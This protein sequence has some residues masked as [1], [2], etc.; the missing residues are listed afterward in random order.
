MTPERAVIASAC[1]ERVESGLTIR[2]VA[3][4]GYGLLQTHLAVAPSPE[5]LPR[6]ESGVPRLGHFPHTSL[7]E[8]LAAT[9]DYAVGLEGMEGG[10][11]AVAIHVSAVDEDRI[12][13]GGWVGEERFV[14]EG[15]PGRF[16][17]LDVKG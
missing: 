4:T 15:H 12:E 6:S 16:F 11:V 17:L 5:A 9:T 2:I 1:T 13:H 3:A 14:E 10:T 7:H 8:A